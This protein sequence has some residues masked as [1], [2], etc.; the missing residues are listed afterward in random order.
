MFL[1]R[2][3]FVVGLE[4]V[5]LRRTPLAIRGDISSGVIERVAE[6]MAGELGWNRD[7]TEHEVET[8][9]ADLGNY[10]GVSRETLNKRTQD[11]SLTCASP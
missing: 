8:F 6:I 7:R 10:H 9:I 1:V 4:D 3:E 5:L 2:N 11:R